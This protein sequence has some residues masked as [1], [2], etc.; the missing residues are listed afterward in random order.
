MQ[1]S[2]A[3]SSSRMTLENKIQ[4]MMDEKRLISIHITEN[5]GQEERA[6][7]FFCQADASGTSKS[8]G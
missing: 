8:V 4:A 5:T 6:G 1:R 3:F 7:I 2:V